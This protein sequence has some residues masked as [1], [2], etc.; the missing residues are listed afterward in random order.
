MK[1]RIESLIICIDEM[2]GLNK[3][4]QVDYEMLYDVV[5]QM[6]SEVILPQL[7]MIGV[8]FDWY[9]PD[10]SYERR[11]YGIFKCCS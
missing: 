7:K 3:H 10:T 6:H 4:P 8:D 1:Q 9:D 5:F 2:I 11:C